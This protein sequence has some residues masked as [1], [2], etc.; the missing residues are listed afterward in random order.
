MKNAEQTFFATK[1]VP[2]SRQVDFNGR[3][4]NELGSAMRIV[5]SAAA[6]ITGTYTSA[7]SETGLPTPEMQLSGTVAGDLICFT[8]NW[9]ESIT[10]WVGHGVHDNGEAR[11]LTLWQMVLAVPDEIEPGHQWKTAMAGADEFRPAP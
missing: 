10:T 6:T 3:W 11:I 9:G 7:V 1:T 2:P 5:V 4:V 8:V